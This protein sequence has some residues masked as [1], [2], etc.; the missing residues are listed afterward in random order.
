MEPKPSE[1]PDAD[2]RSDSWSTHGLPVAL[3]CGN[4]L[5]PFAI[6][7]LYLI[8]ALT[9]HRVISV[10][11]T[12][13][14]LGTSRVF[15]LKREAYPRLCSFVDT[16]AGDLGTAPP[17]QFIAGLDS[18]FFVTEAP[19]VC[20]DGEFSGRT[21]YFS[22]PMCRVLTG[23]EFSADQV[24]ARVADQDAMCSALLKAH[25]YEI[26]WSLTEGEMR[27]SVREGKALMNS[28]SWFSWVVQGVDTA[29]LVAGLGAQ[30]SPHL[31]DTHPPRIVDH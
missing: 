4:P 30:K 27:K 13:M 3:A 9:I 16:L 2:T 28:A 22:V 26:V 25:A 6:M 12:P 7:S 29:K 31:G 19:V 14:R 17:D 10:S 24:G 8:E 1:S 21:F 18:S 5:I 15:S 23:R 20:A 11:M